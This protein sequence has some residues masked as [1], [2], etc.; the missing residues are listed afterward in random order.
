MQHGCVDRLV[1]YQQSEEFV[2]AIREKQPDAIVEF[3]TLPT[4][5]HE[6]KQYGTEE[7]LDI[8]WKFIDQY[9]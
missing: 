6:D 5:D 7:N 9:L 3:T 4:A 2:A 1:P 8:V